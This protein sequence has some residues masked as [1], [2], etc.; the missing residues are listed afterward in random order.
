[1]GPNTWIMDNEIS[2]ELIREL[3]KDGSTYQ[4]VPPYSHCRNRAE[5][6]I[7]TYKS[8]FKAGLA[9]V[10]PDFPLS[11]WDELIE[12]ANITLGLLRTARANPKLSSY[13]YVFGAFD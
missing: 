9:S 5:N 3:E 11:E 12:Q 7:K 8:H 4:L 6:A 1:M 2:G 13:A 10:H